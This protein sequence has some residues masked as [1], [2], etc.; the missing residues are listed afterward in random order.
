MS[1]E[2]E[3]RKRNLQ[4]LKQLKI[5]KLLRNDILQQTIAATLEER[6]VITSPYELLRDEILGQVDIVKRY[7]NIEQFITQ[8]CRVANDE[9]D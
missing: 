9:E 5:Y 1:L 8:Y 7:A 3:Y 2:F 6:E 4:S